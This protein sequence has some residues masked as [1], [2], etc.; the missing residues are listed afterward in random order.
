MNAFGTVF[1][2]EMAQ[3]HFQDGAWSALKVGP[4]QP[5]SLHPSAHVL[6]YASTCF[7]GLKAYRHGDGSVK[8]FR[9][10]SHVARLRH[11]AARLCLPVP[12]EA[13]LEEAITAVV[14]ANRD[15]VPDY[16]GSLYIR[17]VIIGTD[18]DIGAAGHASQGACLFVL[19]S[20]VGAYFQ[21]GQALKI[22]IDDEHMRAT[23]DFGIAKSGGNYASGIHFIET[24]RRDHGADQV[25]FCPG[26]DVQET[27]AANFF[28]LDDTRVVTRALDGSILH[29]ITRDSLLQLARDL[30]YRVE[31]RAITVAEVLAWSA[32]GEAA[33]S[34]TA[35]V[36]VPIGTFLHRGREIPVA[37]GPNA[38]RLRD[39]LA[40]IHGGACA[41]RFGWLTSV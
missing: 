29:G 20:P 41:D 30:G 10:V 28:L 11:S 16:P 15:A 37:T 17:P 22:L 39:A 13:L 35:A 19:A 14:R 32:V 1:A 2:G 40:G 25:L 36:L 23:P 33:L 26:G 12:G 38:A 3:A 27:G 24:A 4:V 31:E 21:G 6:H 34:G 9:L 7:D 18:H 8:I 5:L